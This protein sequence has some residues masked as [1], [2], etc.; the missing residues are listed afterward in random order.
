MSI[1]LNALKKS[2][3]QRRLGKA[4]TL[5]DTAAITGVEESS[6]RFSRWWLILLLVIMLTAGW[7][8]IDLIFP[9]GEFNEQATEPATST[10]TPPDSSGSADFSSQGETANKQ[11][12][13]IAREARTGLSWKRV[14]NTDGSTA[15]DGATVI[16][17][18][19]E[20]Y[21]APEPGY[22]ELG[23]QDGRSGDEGDALP[24]ED[25]ESSVWP[26][27][28]QPN[29]RVGSAPL[30]IYEIPRDIRNTLPEIK[31]TLQVYAEEPEN[32]FALVNGQ[33]MVEG[34]TL[35]DGLVLKE[36]RQ[37]G[38]VFTYRNYRFVIG[39]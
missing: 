34:D 8:A 15:G 27:P 13:D 18:P 32:R 30:T 3:A 29:E 11:L 20:S 22:A 36:I 14:E 35:P 24:G 39:D 6:K 10:Q 7:F 25:R 26:E 37:K 21:S 19:V 33:R 12:D 23:D 5:A 1:I 2:E 4:P 28:V 31:V 9:A 38:L 16:S 17:T